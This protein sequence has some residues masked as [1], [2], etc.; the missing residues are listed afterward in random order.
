MALGIQHI[1]SAGA[2]LQDEVFQLVHFQQSSG[3][4]LSPLAAISSNEQSKERKYLLH[5]GIVLLNLAS[6]PTL[7]KGM[8]PACVHVIYSYQHG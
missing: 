4:I 1:V 7:L 8:L 5:L 2:D 6:F 3:G